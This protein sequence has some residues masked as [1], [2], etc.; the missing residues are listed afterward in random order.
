MSSRVIVLLLLALVSC[1]LVLV[2]TQYQARHLFIELERAQTQ[3]RQLEID[4]SQ[5]QLDQSNFSKH[6]RIELSAVQ[7]LMMVP[8]T[9][10]HTQYLTLINKN[11]SEKINE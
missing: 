2:K 1:A 7:D 11:K 10:E 8:V 9:A 3:A 4:W 5:L 6:E